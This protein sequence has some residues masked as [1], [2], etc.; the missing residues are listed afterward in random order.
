MVCLELSVSAVKAQHSQESLRLK[1]SRTV[2]TLYS[3]SL[4]WPWSSG[5]SREPDDLGESRV[6]S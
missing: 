4:A 3:G 2:G 6:R 1:P 5:G